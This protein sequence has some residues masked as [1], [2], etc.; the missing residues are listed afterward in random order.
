MNEGN[1][2][3]FEKLS[4]EI[5]GKLK[6]FEESFADKFNSQKKILKDIENE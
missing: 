5:A 2:D 6:H 1:S 4:R 3:H